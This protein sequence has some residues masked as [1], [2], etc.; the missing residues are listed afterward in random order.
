MLAMDFVMEPVAP[1][2]DMWRFENLIVPSSN[3]IGWLIIGL[4]TQTIY[5]LLFRKK[6]IIVFVSLLDQ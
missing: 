3:Y 4:V 2:L 5:N 6:E 1:K